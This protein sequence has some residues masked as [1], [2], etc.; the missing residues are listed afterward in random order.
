MAYREIAM[1]EILEVLRRVHRGAQQRAIQQVT[2]HSRST[3]RRRV[4]TATE[5][6]WA[7][8]VQVPDAAL[9]RRVAQRMRPVPERPEAGESQARLRP[10][11][12]RIR[13]W[14]QPAEGS[15]GPRLSKVHQLLGDKKD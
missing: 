3:I 1:W 6:G 10:H 14:L 5:L 8:A 13:A 12:A 9:A 15:R 11:Q 2:G 7:A 4:A